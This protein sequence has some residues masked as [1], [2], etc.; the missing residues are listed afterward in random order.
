VG[1]DVLVSANAATLTGPAGACCHGFDSV[2][3]GAYFGFVCSVHV[4]T[5]EGRGAEDGAWE[6]REGQGGG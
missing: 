6:G 5:G 1:H 2:S 4:H 3:Y